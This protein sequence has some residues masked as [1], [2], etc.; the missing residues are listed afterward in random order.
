MNQGVEI[1]FP[2]PGVVVFRHETSCSPVKFCSKVVEVDHQS[3]TGE[4]QNGFLY[5]ARFQL[6]YFSLCYNH[7]GSLKLTH[8]LETFKQ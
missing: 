4:G 2:K 8:Y 5:N 1:F 7:M 3:K 6:S